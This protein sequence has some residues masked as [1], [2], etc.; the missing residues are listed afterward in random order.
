[1]DGVF[2]W[3]WWLIR[4]NGLIRLGGRLDGVVD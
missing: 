4:W 2:D 1:M 3:M